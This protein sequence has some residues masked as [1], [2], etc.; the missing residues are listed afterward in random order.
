LFGIAPKTPIIEENDPVVVTGITE[1]TI[2][3]ISV[4]TYTPGSATN[5]GEVES[6]QSVPS[7]HD[8][9]S[10]IQQGEALGL[11]GDHAGAI[12]A[13][14]QA[15]AIN[16]SNH[17]AWF[18]RGVMSESSGD[19]DEAIKAFNI[20]LDNCPG[21]GATSANM[22]VLMERLGHSDKAV[23]HAQSGLVAFP[24][25]PALVEIVN[26][27]EDE[28]GEGQGLVT[29]SLHSDEVEESEIEDSVD[30]QIQDSEPEQTWAEPQ[31]SI[32][33]MTDEVPA[34]N[35]VIEDSQPQQNTEIDLDGI[36]D[37]AADMIRAGD[38]AA[39][40]ESLR[41]LLPGAAC[42]HPQSWCVAAGAMARLDLEDSAIEA[43]AYALDLDDT[44][45]SAWFNLGAL[46]RR[47]EDHS[48]AADCFSR[49][50]DLDSGYA[51]AANGLALASL[52]IGA[53]ENAIHGFRVLLSL[54]PEHASAYDFASLLIDLAEGEGR[55]I[56]LVESL[57]T[58]LPA[59]PEMAS[60]ALRH[61]QVE[62]SRENIIL[63]A[64]ANTI[65]ANHAES[66]TLWKSLLESDKTDATLWMGLAGALTAAG[67]ADMATAC[68]EKAR[69]LGADVE[70]PAPIP[71]EHNLELA[72]DTL[73][74]HTEETVT[75]PVE[76]PNDDPWGALSDDSEES[77]SNDVS[78]IS[79]EEIMQ[80]ESALDTISE[81]EP[82]TYEPVGQDVDLAAAALEAQANIMEDH[83]VMADSSSV[84]NQDIEWYN[85]GLEL[86]S[87]D[88]FSEALSCFDRA[89]PSFKDDNAMAIKVLNGRGN[90]FYY[91]EQYKKAIESYFKAFGIDKKL[92]T[93]NALYNMGTAYAELE[94]YE[95]AIHCF[96]QAMGKEVGEPL[97]GE[98]KKRCKEQIRRCKLLLK[99]QKKKS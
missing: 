94:S 55:V 34:T 7:E 89:L 12:N 53:I 62:N 86:L 16:P 73:V 60:E 77:S 75:N 92:T 37:R 70:E 21:H 45:S 99:E 24:G 1:T 4:P 44:D 63:R 74:E 96:N 50:L 42:E 56:E 22:A 36:A 14:N 6:H 78:E 18:N 31:G 88:R 83:R 25:H 79:S 43:F 61:L 17:M 59:G 51:K 40:L 97:K 20:A 47:R 66:V 49:A 19:I 95:N 90:C 65:I 76:E 11:A 91:M 3:D 8:E 41:D 29:D 15:I 67:S 10:L 13:F 46:K 27:F 39:A 69:A 26:R 57:P 48:G 68:R 54:E 9:D 35:A 58:T 85:K 71:I 80:H 32:R 87:K 2:G 38:P 30:N 98:T 33:T 81:P 23:Q 28:H 82:I 52:E 64:R 93:G 72:N 5:E 84:A